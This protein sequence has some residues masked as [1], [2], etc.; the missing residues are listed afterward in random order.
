MDRDRHVGEE[1]FRVDMTGPTVFIS[2]SHKDE[3][4]KDRLVTHLG[5]LQH[6]ILLDLWHDRRI[7]AGEGWHEEIRTSLDAASV[8]ILLVSFH[9]LDSKFIREEEVPRLLK[10]R[11]EGGLRLYP[12][13][14]SP[15]AWPAVDWLCQLQVRPRDGRPLSTGGENRINADLAAMAMEIYD[16]LKQSA[17]P[18]ASRVFVPLA[19]DYIS[20]SKLPPTGPFLCGREQELKKLNDS[21]AD[22]DTNIVSVVA[23]SGVGKSTLINHWLR[24]MLR[25]NYR[26]AERVFAWSFY[27][28]GTADRGASADLFI[29]SA[30]RW[31]N[32]CN[33]NRIPDRELDEGSPWDK[34]ERLARLIRAR[35]TLLVLDGLE[36]LQF[37]PG[38][39]EGRLRDQALQALL[40]ELAVKSPG[41]CVI[42]TRL[43]VTDLEDFERSTAR[44]IDLTH[45]TPRAGAQLLKELGVK[46]D[47]AELEQAAR[48]FR[49][50]PLALILLGSFLNDAHGGDVRC[51]R[52]VGPLEEEVRQGG[53][54]RRVMAS[55]EKWFGEGPELAVMRLLALFN[56][57]A[58]G[59]A[60]NILRAA[61]AIPGLTDTLQ[62]LDARAWD[63]VL[64]KLC[65][66]Q[67]LTKQERNRL[68]KT[69][70]THPLVREHF[71]LQLQQKSPDAWQKG[72]K[73]LYEYFKRQA[74]E[75]LKKP[76]E[77]RHKRRPTTIE[78]MDP[79]FTAVFHGC[80][81]G[82]HRRAFYEVYWPR[83]SR[84]KRYYIA[85]RRFAFGAD[86]AVLSN[87]FD[88]P[89]CL[90]VD[91]LKAIH[92][93]EILS[94]CGL[95]LFSLGRLE[96]AVKSLEAGLHRA[97]SQKDWRKAAV[98]ASHLCR[99]YSIA[100]GLDKAL[101]VA[102]CGVKYADRSGNAI[103]RWRR[104]AT[105]GGVLHLMG[106]LSA[107]EAEFREAEDLQ[108]Q[109]QSSPHAS[110]RR[111]VHWLIHR[112][113]S[114]KVNV[115]DDLSVFP[116]LSSIHGFRYCSLLLDQG[117]SNPEKYQEV[118]DRATLLLERTRKGQDSVFDDALS[119]L[120]LGRTFLLQSLRNR[121]AAIP[122]AEEHLDK[123]VVG[124][125]R[126]GIRHYLVR[127][128]LSQAALYITNKELNKAQANLKEAALIARHDH[129]RLHQ[130]DCHLAYARL[131]LARGAKG[132]AQR[133]LTKAKAM[134]ERMGYHRRDREVAELEGRL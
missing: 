8:A 15:C 93:V 17:P 109:W 2:Y 75:G 47:E 10:R 7:G 130:A 54:A 4:W 24:E 68:E 66:A 59:P 80:Q 25:D 37:P 86:L 62:A 118:Q 61:P 58:D 53:H 96:E 90:P 108:N 123:A 101:Q 49:G 125:R 124:L 128:L 19:P 97:I 89:Y 70:D 132:K 31:S 71:G 74:S 95:R 81:A 100:G 127:G 114:G 107:A 113:P 91:K 52:E 67:L 14:V 12:I 65:R 21:W 104:H 126:A 16:L 1:E 117:K 102:A 23:W 35:R 106:K 120:S 44:R 18:A 45:L 33:R 42:S 36:S 129:M 98:S 3:G 57:P 43:P 85:K 27:S 134:I 34:G 30:L 88:W 22:P 133:N 29:E 64:S 103:Q 46:G 69:L 77:K 121:P 122:L 40:R 63:Q 105:L 79:F 116:F 39:Q 6:Q 50:H 84:G 41:L 9:F 119:H 48:E 131:H 11:E 94:V 78:E 5:A 32:N 92:Q 115:P 55:Y 20:T 83:I 38:P 87:F 82:L 56:R 60:V 73:R 76:D 28:Q 112:S 110:I 99:V 26:G 13:I 51:W 72:N 111:F